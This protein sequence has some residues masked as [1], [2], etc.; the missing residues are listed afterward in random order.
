MKLPWY[1]LTLAVHAIP[2]RSPELNLGLMCHSQITTAG[3][4][5]QAKDKKW[6]K[7]GLLLQ[8]YPGIANV[9]PKG[10]WPA[11]CQAAEVAQ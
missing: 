7:V 1:D 6:Y 10:R 2:G 9:S 11:L 8:L 3:T 5:G 4:K